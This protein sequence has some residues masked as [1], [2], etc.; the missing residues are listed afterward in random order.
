[1]CFRGGS[2][3]S[4]PVSNTGG[5]QVENP[6]HTSSAVHDLFQ[7]MYRN[8]PPRHGASLPDTRPQQIPESSKGF[9]AHVSQQNKHPLTP[10]RNSSETVANI[11]TSTN[12]TSPRI[13]S[14]VL[15]QNNQGYVPT[16]LTPNDEESS[17]YSEYNQGSGQ[18]MVYRNYKPDASLNSSTDS[19]VYLDAQQNLPRQNSSLSSQSSNFVEPSSFSSCASEM[20]DITHANTLPSHEDKEQASPSPPPLPAQPPPPL[21]SP[22]SPGLDS[23]GTELPPPPPS[24]LESM[25]EEISS[26]E[27]R[28]WNPGQGNPTSPEGK[29]N[30]VTKC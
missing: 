3:P 14:S 23:P 26:N 17:I 28:S 16:P 4:G 27:S 29:S 20:S 21:P 9:S 12:P 30:E 7:D 22:S 19:G 1:M 5:A 10:Q 24:L 13:E 11:Q 8:T 6:A 18:G 15:S 2:A 25:P